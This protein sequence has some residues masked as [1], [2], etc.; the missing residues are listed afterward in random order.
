[1]PVAALQTIPKG[2]DV[3]IDSNIFIYALNGQSGQ[4]RTLLEKISRE[5]ITGITS[6]HVVG[7]V[8]HQLMVAELIAA[9]GPGA[10]K[11]RKYLEEHPQVVQRLTQY[12]VGTESVLAMNL[13][14]LT[15]DEG[16]IKGAHPIRQQSGLLNNDSLVAACMKYLGLTFI[17]SNDKCF[18]A[19][20]GFSVFK[21]TDL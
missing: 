3:F 2:A 13:L 10:A 17:A 1:M 19:V 16:I 5:E 7:E 12:W 21:P 20:T 8:T 4:C 6:Y 9:G 15:V 11:P 14:F 18:D